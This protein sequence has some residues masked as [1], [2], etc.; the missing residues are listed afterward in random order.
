MSPIGITAAGEPLAVDLD[1]LIGAHACVAANSGGGKSG[2]I[3]RL[4]EVTHGHVQHLVLDPEDEFY[5][6]RERFD[7]VIAGGDG[8]DAPATVAGAPALARAALANG[9]SLIA[10]IN[11]LGEGAADFIAAFCDA[12]ISA[13]REQWRP[14]LVVIDEAQRFAPSTGGSVA[15][16]ALKNLLQRGRKRGFTAVVAST[17]VSELHPGVRGLCRN[18]MLGLVGQALD[19]RTAAAQLGFGPSSAEAKALQSLEPR[20]FWGFGP[21]IARQP[22]LFRV[23]QVETTIVRSGQAKVPTPPAPEALREILAGLAAPVAEAADGPAEAAQEMVARDRR[24]AELDAELAAADQRE[25]ELDRQCDRYDDA[26]TAI[27][28]VIRAVRHGRPP[29]ETAPAEPS[30]ADVEGAP[31]AAAGTPPTPPSA[32][33]PDRQ[34]GAE[35]K[36]LAMLAGIAPAGLTDAAWATLA[37]FKRSGGTWTTYRSRL[38]TAGL[39]EQV[40]GKWRATVAGVAAIGGEAADVPAP[41]LALVKF[42]AERVP[43]AGRMLLRLG[44]LYPKALKKDALAADLNMAAKGGTFGTY[45]SRLRGNGLLE[46]KDGRIR[47]APALM[48]DEL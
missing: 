23:G 2:L 34:L 35:R 10:Q 3:R 43:G 41:G 29:P 39:I 14:L 21:A 47:L 25:A 13:P 48:G 45:L 16:S 40:D 22:V 11:D 33:A 28:D 36:P 38:R 32:G 27:E 9:F 19:R 26:L 30:E 18:W 42:W 24:I 5:T 17:R 6:L 44:Q 1:A 46:E 15:T 37:G 4:L 12:L 7:Y 20:Q 31:A 8:G